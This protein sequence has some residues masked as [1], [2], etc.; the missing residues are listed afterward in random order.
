M[1]CGRYVLF[2]DTEEKG[3]RDIIDEVQRKV[4][5]EIKTGEIFPTD[6]APV[7]IQEQN[8]ITPEVLAWGFP[9]FR[10]KGVIINARSETVQEKAMFRKCLFTR[11]C[12]IPSTGFYEW[13]H[14]GEKLKYQFNLPHTRALYMAGLYDEFDGKQRYVILTTEANDSMSDI[15]NRMPVVLDREEVQQWVANPECAIKILNEKHPLLEK[16]LVV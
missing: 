15:H 16:R 10:N 4:N 13:S 7:L 2:S 8:R 6:K 3:I 12:V 14:N 5:G 1:M 9:N 11:R